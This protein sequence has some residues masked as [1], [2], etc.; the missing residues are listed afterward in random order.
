VTGGKDQRG[1]ATVN[2]WPLQGQPAA[3][4]PTKIVP[5]WVALKLKPVLC[6]V[7]GELGVLGG[8][9]QPNLHGGSVVLRS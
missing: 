6:P 5:E 7:K 9:V 3:A 2:P 8:W 1:E 4:E